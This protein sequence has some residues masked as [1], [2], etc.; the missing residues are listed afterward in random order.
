[1]TP[2]AVI[3]I[4]VTFVRLKINVNTSTN[5]EKDKLKPW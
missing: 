1:M 3:V 4:E 5:I 2:A